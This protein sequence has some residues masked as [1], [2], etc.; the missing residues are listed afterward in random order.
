MLCGLSGQGKWVR[1]DPGLEETVHRMALADVIWRK[2]DGCQFIQGDSDEV[3][4]RDKITMG[5][6]LFRDPVLKYAGFDRMD[7]EGSL[8]FRQE[9]QSG[10]P[11]PSG[12]KARIYIGMPEGQRELL[13]AGKLGRECKP[14]SFHLRSHEY[15]A[16]P[17][18]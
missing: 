11:F 18:G 2:P 16:L 6:W 5:A 1:L 14:A 15:G 13:S 17:W 4:L 7:F 3:D 12:G 8:G 10:I 9:G